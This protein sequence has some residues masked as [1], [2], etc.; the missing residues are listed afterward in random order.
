[1]YNFKPIEKQLD[2]KKEKENQ[3]QDF[4]TLMQDYLKLF[5]QPETPYVAQ[6]AQDQGEYQPNE[7][8]IY[9][10]QQAQDEGNFQPEEDMPY[11]AYQSQIEDE[12]QPPLPEQDLFSDY[13][14]M[15][16]TGGADAQVYQ[17]PLLDGDLNRVDLQEPVMEDEG[18]M[19]IDGYNTV[20]PPVQTQAPKMIN[21]DLEANIQLVNEALP[22]KQANIIEQ[23]LITA[24]EDP[25]IKGLSYRWA[26]ELVDKVLTTFGT[27]QA[28]IDDWREKLKKSK[29]DNLVSKGIDFTAE[30]A[31]GSLP[32][33]ALGGLAQGAVRGLGA[34]GRI[35][36]AGMQGA[37]EGSIYGA[38]A[39]EDGKRWEDAGT[40]ALIGG[41]LGGATQGI[42]EGL[43]KYKAGDLSKAGK[44]RV[45]EFLDSPSDYA[46]AKNVTAD[47]FKKALNSRLNEA[48][49][50]IQSSSNNPQAKKA[51]Q[52]FKK[53]LE[54]IIKPFKKGN[55]WLPDNQITPD[56]VK[57]FE[58]AFYML[59]DKQP[60]FSKVATELG[61]NNPE[62]IQRTRDFAGMQRLKP[63]YEGKELVT[64]GDIGA[65]A[66]GFALGGVPGAGGILAAKKMADKIPIQT[67]IDLVN[68][69]LPRLFGK[70]ATQ[71]LVKAERESKDM[72]EAF[73]VNDD[74]TEALSFLPRLSDFQP[75]QPQIS[76]QGDAQLPSLNVPARQYD[77]GVETRLN[78]FYEELKKGR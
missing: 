3:P 66:A 54:N 24:G 68:S 33:M 14:N 29:P 8:E 65:G 64:R 31:G 28:T 48:E 37:I 44:D 51:Y 52:S 36:A 23:L 2:S 34:L 45:R 40:G 7:E 12:Y 56:K 57:Q 73:T 21:P 71:E 11:V 59:K 46:R 77:K 70:T 25:V 60:L 27:E 19:L 10:A 41:V 74:N 17:P 32:S 20:A 69:P 35:S 15:F 67:A 30:M 6:Q 38:G 63:E 76:P 78:R 9:F 55:D 43:V 50:L 4:N 75:S 49:G 47:E 39:S 72:A 62:P 22:P 53:D 18:S 1:M 61:S 26:D 58:D 13:L 42:G 16:D 5:N